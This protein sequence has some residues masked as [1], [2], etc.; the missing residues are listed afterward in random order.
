MAVL[1]WFL[2][3]I[4]GKTVSNTDFLKIR[5]NKTTLAV[6]H[7]S[8]N[9]ESSP[10]SSSKGP[11]R[12]LNS[13]GNVTNDAFD[14]LLQLL[15]VTSSTN[16][17]NPVTSSNNQ[18]E[19]PISKPTSINLIKTARNLSHS[20]PNLCSSSSD[21]DVDSD[22]L[23]GAVGGAKNTAG[24]SFLDDTSSD[25][26][27]ET[28]TI[29]GENFVEYAEIAMEQRVKQQ[30]NA[31]DNIAIDDELMLLTL[32]DQSVN[33]PK[34][35]LTRQVGNAFADTPTNR[36]SVNLENDEQ[37]DRMSNFK[38]NP[39][40]S[41]SSGPLIW[42]LAASIQKQDNGTSHRN[43]ADA[44]DVAFHTFEP[45]SKSSTIDTQSVPGRKFLARAKATNCVT[46]TTNEIFYND[47]FSPITSTSSNSSGENPI[48]MP[49]F[50]P[51]LV[52]KSENQKSTSLI[53]KENKRNN[54]ADRYS[55]FSLQDEDLFANF[56]ATAMEN[57]NL[58][59][60]TKTNSER[61]NSS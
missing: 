48:F 25:E 2:S 21:L 6:N 17:P 20:S 30:N 59:R 26:D 52:T 56:N 33:L 8:A 1:N 36:N 46:P 55:V 45:I 44:Q 4:N 9:N 35:N 47:L 19:K 37:I 5:E 39:L 15:N 28:D 57:V 41:S 18:Q 13:G 61:P 14:D 54:N 24:K 12:K 43:S 38:S 40:S 7:A 22:C 58:K 32:F 31:G 16:S 11:S 27:P 3:R 42:K 29:S 60:E 53:N 10:I 50:Q 34:R 23:M 51:T 49:S